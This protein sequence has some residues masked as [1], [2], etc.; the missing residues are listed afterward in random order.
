MSEDY[1]KALA[2]YL[3]LIDND[4]QNAYWW[5]GAAECY[6]ATQNYDRTSFACLKAVELD[7]KLAIPHV[8]LA[9]VYFKM[10]K[11]K[12]SMAE[13][14]IAYTLA[15][16]SER[17]L[18]CYGTILLATDKVDE[19][20]PF[21]SRAL[22]INAKL[23]SA[24]NNLALAYRRKGNNKQYLKEMML[25][26]RQRPSLT[27]LLRLWSAFQQRYAWLL[28]GLT[29]A[30][31]IAAYIFRISLLLLL[32]VYVV[33]K[34]WWIAFQFAA[35]RKWKDAAIYFTSYSILGFLLYKVYL[36]I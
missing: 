2:A 4:P 16:S 13:A 3:E 9:F 28:T 24:R 27:N 29:I 20:I 10:N 26:Y 23:I 17:V 35:T 34:G 18:D 6:Y 7:A 25:V 36:S 12:E 30:C 11:T 19:A 21:L 22:S 5:Q 33:V 14:E 15:P 1:P 32:P 31:I 8:L